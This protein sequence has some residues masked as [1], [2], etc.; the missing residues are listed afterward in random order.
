MKNYYELLGVSPDISDKDLRKKIQQILR[1]NHPDINP[2]DEKK[3]KIYKAVSYAGSILSNP[4]KRKEYD[5]KLGISQ[6]ESNFNFFYNNSSY[7]NQQ[8]DNM[9]SI[10]LRINEL[11][12]QIKE[13]EKNVLDIK[14]QIKHVEHYQYNM[15]LGEIN[16][17]RSAEIAAISSR[18]TN[19][20]NRKRFISTFFPNIDRKIIA[21]HESQIQEVNKN[22]DEKISLLNNLW[23]EKL[24]REDDYNKEKTDEMDKLLSSKQVLEEKINELLRNIYGNNY[25][26]NLGKGKK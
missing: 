13:I 19:E 18:M 25:T 3:E 9:G 26:T 6:S 22:A 14:G 21:K 16:Q 1:D 23:E 7:G 17:E 11:R 5:K 20:R 4:E 15:E 12:K 24:K 8:S 10:T 2:G